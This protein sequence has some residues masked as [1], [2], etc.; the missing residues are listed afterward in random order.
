MSVTLNIS[1]EF[2]TIYQK[3]TFQRNQL[4]E[5]LYMPNPTDMCFG[6]V[7]TT[8]ERCAIKGRAE[9]ETKVQ[10]F[11]CEFTPDCS[12]AFDSYEHN[13]CHVKVDCKF[14]PDDLTEEFN[15]FW[16]GV[17]QNDRSRWPFARWFA[18][19]KMRYIQEDM[20][21]RLI[22][23]GIK[24]DIPTPGTAHFDGFKGFGTQIND[25]IDAGDISTANGNLIALTPSADPVTF[26]EQMIDWVKQVRASSK[27]AKL[28][29]FDKIMMSCT[30]RDRFAVGLDLKYN[31]AYSRWG[32]SLKNELENQEAALCV[33]YTQIGIVG[34]PSMEGGDKIIMSIAWNKWNYVRSMGRKN[35]PLAGICEGGR[36]VWM[37]M[38]WWKGLGF[39]MAQFVYTND[40]DVA[41]VSP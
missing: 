20:E 26:V 38:D 36:E 31:G 37:A 35:F 12:F 27:E 17:D 1:Q 21:C 25:W 3:D 40:Q 4:L 41:F 13:L 16:E 28:L 19:E 2:E 32:I 30:L 11:Q 22:Y 5:K 34:L 14:C 39:W 33:P 15:S 6:P 10:A 18:E 7:R 8:P 24:S 9:I 23:R 29:K